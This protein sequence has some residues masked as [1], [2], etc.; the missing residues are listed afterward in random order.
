M[1]LKQRNQTKPNQLTLLQKCKEKQYY[2][3]LK[4][5]PGEI[6][7]EKSCTWQMK[8]NLKRETDPF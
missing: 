8:E 7:H 4:R 6:P 3:Y 5:T 2:E 1:L